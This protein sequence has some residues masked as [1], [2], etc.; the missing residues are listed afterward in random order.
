ML[1]SG[2]VVF[3]RR[4]KTRHYD[5][6]WDALGIAGVLGEI[7]HFVQDD[8]ALIREGGGAP[9][10]GGGQPQDGMRWMRLGLGILPANTGA[11]MKAQNGRH[12]CRPYIDIQKTP[13]K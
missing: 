6:R 5:M 1:S 4:V 2:D 13:G 12:A 7:L 9:P 3:H 11:T 8:N 10:R